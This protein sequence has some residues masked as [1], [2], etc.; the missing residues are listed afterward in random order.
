MIFHDELRSGWR[1]ICLAFLGIAFSMPAMP[2][3]GWGMFIPHVSEDF[4][5]SIA[6]TS[7]GLT[8]LTL[9][10]ALCTPVGGWLVDRFGLYRSILFSM[11]ATFLPV[12]GLTLVDGSTHGYLLLW[13]CAAVAG[14][15]SSEHLAQLAA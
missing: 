3:Y 6:Q 8:A 10:M 7:S 14:C 5:W 11:P 12:A 2:I 4:G 15:P 1:I 13:V 9:V